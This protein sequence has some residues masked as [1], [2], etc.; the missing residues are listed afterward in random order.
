MKILTYENHEPFKDPSQVLMF[1]LQRTEK[2]E[3]ENMK[4]RDRSGK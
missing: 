1:T 3:I 2:W 4:N